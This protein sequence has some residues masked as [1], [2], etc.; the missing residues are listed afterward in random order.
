MVFSFFMYCFAI[1]TGILFFNIGNISSHA[2]NEFVLKFKD[3][4]YGSLAFGVGGITI[5]KD[6]NNRLNAYIKEFH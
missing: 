2:T 1:L 3:L 4:G 6:Q 5:V